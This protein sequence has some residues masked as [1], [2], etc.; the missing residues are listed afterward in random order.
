MHKISFILA[1]IC[2]ATDISTAGFD[3]SIGAFLVV[4]NVVIISFVR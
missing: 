1:D 3:I 4:R 2:T